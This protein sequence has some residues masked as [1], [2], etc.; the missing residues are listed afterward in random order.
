MFLNL[1]HLFNSAFLKPLWTRTPLLAAKSIPRKSWFWLNMVLL[2]VCPPWRRHYCRVRRLAWCNDPE[3]YADVSVATGR[4][5]LAGQVKEGHPDKERY[6]GPPGWGLGVLLENAPL[7]K[8]IA[9]KVQRGNSGQMQGRCKLLVGGRSSRID[10][11]G[12]ELLNR[13]KPTQG[14]RV[15]RRRRR[16][17]VT[18]NRIN[19]WFFKLIISGRGTQYY[20]S[21]QALKKNPRYA[22][23]HARTLF[24]FTSLRSNQDISLQNLWATSDNSKD[25]TERNTIVGR[26]IVSNRNLVNTNNS[27]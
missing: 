1:Y 13:P 21:P 4:A 24:W 7:K 22:T 26:S 9:A 25:F 14:C 11:G 5:T 18:R 20:F 15:N 27:T 23:V 3:S 12:I 10:R 6:P 17:Q 2:E 19:D 8:F 16:S